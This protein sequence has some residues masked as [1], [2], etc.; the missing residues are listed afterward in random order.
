MRTLSQKSYH[1]QTDNRMHKLFCLV[2][3]ICT[4]ALPSA[5]QKQVYSIGILTDIS[6]AE[7][8]PLL[9]QV[10]DQIKAVV[11]ED[12]T[13]LFEEENALVNN[14]SLEAATQNY[15]QLLSNST[16]IILAFGAVNNLVIGQQERYPK[17]TILF[18]IINKDLVEIDQNKTTSGIENF[19]YL[20]QSESYINDITKF[21]ELTDFKKLGIVIEQQ[22]MGILPVEE[23][24]KKKLPPLEVDYKIIPFKD[25][26]DITS[27]LDGMDAIYL[28]GG[29]LLPPDEIK[30]LAD[31]FIS[32]KIPAFT[33]TNIED[34][35]NGLFATNEGANNIEQIQRRI[36]LTV[37]AYVNG[38]ALS[39]LPVFIDYEPRLT[40]NFNTAELIGVPIKYSLI[41]TTD[42]VGDVNNA[43]AEQNYS[44][45]S[46]VAQALD[47]NPSLAASQKNIDLNSQ[48]IQIAKSDYLPLV[49]A[50][51][52]ATYI[53]PKL[54]EVS[55]GQNPEFS[56]SGAITASQLIYSR[57]VKVNIDIQKKLLAAQQEN[58]NADQL[59]MVADVSNI[60]LAT[61][62]AKVNAQIQ[63]QNLD[64]TKQNLQLA[65]QNFEVGETGKSDVLRFESE[66]AQ[67]TQSMVEAIN[68]LEQN[69]VRLNQLL[70]NPIDREIDIEDLVLNEGLLEKY[71]YDE[72]TTF[73]DNP[74]LRDQFIEFLVQEALLNAPEIRELGYNLEATE[75][76]IALFGKG[77]YYPNIAAQGQYNAVFSRSGAGSETELV[78]GGSIQ[79]TN[80]NLGV[81][82]SMPIFNQNQNNINQ[83]TAKIQKEQLLLNQDNL[84]LAIAANVR[85]NVLTL[86]NQI[87]NIQLSEISERTAKEALELTQTAYSSGAVNLIQLLDAQNN[88]L[89]AQL[90][91]AAAVYNFLIN[92]IQLERS[93]GYYFLLNTEEKNSDFR[94]RFFDFINNASN[95]K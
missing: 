12:A 11:G 94:R 91:K 23:V 58:F 5:A 7:V 64:L 61:L 34:V 13:I 51:V 3:L 89:N 17:P 95:D 38:A 90:A 55:F 9:D 59:D 8:T 69:F 71:D 78:T 93:L 60:Y 35:Q 77:R 54:A 40:I 73:L 47:K 29:F 86:V 39:D 87:S 4:I 16:D 66:V 48:D 10:K 19:T 18:G 62:I 50:G 36:A 26:G 41:S 37:E 32:Q 67:N 28:A 25:V 15:Q 44:L 2:L 24:F 20:I 68:Q 53:D 74:N 46:A 84:E 63:L 72:L 83:Q 81:N 27:N 30:Q 82:I 65:K 42:F 31:T 14:F 56:T 33:N 22:L 79:N 43:V 70:N 75:Y 6:T 52:T 49:E 88:Y 85:T 92:S 21:K 76:S 80:Y 1:R 57:A 45:L